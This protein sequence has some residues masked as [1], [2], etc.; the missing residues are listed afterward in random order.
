MSDTPTLDLPMRRKPQG[1]FRSDGSYDE[2]QNKGERK[3]LDAAW[4][5]QKKEWFDSLPECQREVIRWYSSVDKFAPADSRMR[6]MARFLMKLTGSNSLPK[7][8]G[9]YELVYSNFDAFKAHVLE[10]L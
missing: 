3:L 4:K 7:A 9:Q 8:E 1:Y 2:V 5:K 6:C 10:S